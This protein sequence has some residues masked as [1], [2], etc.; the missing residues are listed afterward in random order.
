[1]KDLPPCHGSQAALAGCKW[2]FA[3]NRWVY[4]QFSSS[5]GKK[6]NIRGFGGDIQKGNFEFSDQTDCKIWEVGAGSKP[7]CRLMLLVRSSA[8]ML[9]DGGWLMV[10]LV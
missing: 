8:Q 3:V 2:T 1:M 10:E 6:I 5:S 4:P 9:V 7:G